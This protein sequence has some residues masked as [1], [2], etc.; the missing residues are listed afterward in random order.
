MEPIKA[1]YEKEKEEL[2]SEIAFQ[3]ADQSNEEAVRQE[4]DVWVSFTEK[5]GNIQIQVDYTSTNMDS[6]YAEDTMQELAELYR[7]E[8]MARNLEKKAAVYHR[9]RGLFWW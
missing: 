2:E 1:L 6:N 9:R 7:D 8:I 4:A 5:E 3:G